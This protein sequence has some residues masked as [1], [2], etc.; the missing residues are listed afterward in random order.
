MIHPAH[1]SIVCD[2]VSAWSQFLRSTC[3][4]AA[5]TLSF[6]LL[7]LGATPDSA[8]EPEN[9]PT[10][11]LV[12]AIDVPEST[13]AHTEIWVSGNLPQLGSWNGRGIQARAEG[14]RY[15]AQVQLP[16]G[17]RVEFKVTRGSW[18]TVEKGRSGEE[19]P[20]RRVTVGTRDTVDVRVHTWRDQITSTPPPASRTGDLRLHPQ[21][22][23]QWLDSPRDILV[24]LPPSY[25]Q[26]ATR[27]YPVLYMHDGQNL[28]DRATSFLG[29][30][31]EVDETAQRLIA[32]GQV[33]PLIVVGIY[34][35]PRRI[36]EYTPVEND[37]RGGNADA[38]ARFL[39]EELKPFIDETYRTRPGRADTGVAGSSLG[40]LVSLY[41]AARYP[42]VFSRVAALSPS[43]WWAEHDILDRVSG[44]SPA[45]LRIW[46]DMG[47][48]E[49][50]SRQGA[51][52]AVEDAR[53]LRSA[54]LD[55]GFV[56]GETVRY[57]EDEGAIHHESAWAERFDEI[58]AF[59][60]PAHPTRP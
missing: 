37:G 40:G 17:A 6:I 4:L 46:I 23:S 45:E 24:Y 51:A 49:A 35:G 50:S 10:A 14:G 1:P 27:R 42:D 48:A 7:F 57:L 41:L 8:A 58:L 52:Q 53:A 11:R 26:E 15:C 34:N 9:N 18:D 30:E 16:A 59:L 43:V 20:N 44:L 5:A 32:E 36:D 25:E 2:S 13:P 54:L 56:L 38:Y 22:P 12:F 33:E 21:I 28:F 39:V 55:Q 47:T 31:W 60:F 19:I 29:V 3:K